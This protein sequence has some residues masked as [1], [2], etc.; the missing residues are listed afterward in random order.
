MS[1]ARRYRALLIGNSVFAAESGLPNLYGPAADIG[2]MRAALTDAEFGLH[3]PEDVTEIVDADSGRIFQEIERFADAGR[4]EQ[5]LV[6]YSGHGVRWD[7]DLLLYARNTDKRTKRATAVSSADVNQLLR[8]SRASAK[9]LVL[10]CCYSGNVRLKGIPAFANGRGH[11]VL[12]S[13]EIDKTVPDADRPGEPSPFTRLLCDALLGGASDGDRDGLLT[14]DDVYRY[15]CDRMGNEVP[16][17]LPTINDRLVGALA[18]ARRPAEGD[19]APAPRRLDATESAAGFVAALGHERRHD[20][21]TARPLYR[22]V[23]ESGHGDWATLAGLRLAA[24]AAADADRETASRAY[25]AVVESGHPEWSTQAAYALATLHA[26]A[27]EDREA[28]QL[29]RDA[30]DRGHPHWSFLAARTLGI[31]LAGRGPEREAAVR[32]LQQA[33][34]LPHVDAPQAATE[35]GDLLVALGRTD[36]AHSA[37]RRAGPGRPD[38]P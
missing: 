9:V 32:Y 1:D 24:I 30:A 23:A 6:Y 18:I 11:V 36:E 13:T 29:L 33:A 38:R 17:W 21:A 37:Y 35:L 7:Q 31:R 34:A 5:I 3:R 12:A 25:R 20:V 15:L 10:D 19:P 27:G 2:L 28:D 22:M 14:I 4:G 8:L 16:D 26:E